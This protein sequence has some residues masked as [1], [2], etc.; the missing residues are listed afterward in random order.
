MLRVYGML[1]QC[2]CLGCEHSHT[3]SCWIEKNIVALL[4]HHFLKQCQVTFV[5]HIHQEL[6]VLVRH[7]CY[8]IAFM[9]GP[10][11]FVLSFLGVFLSFW[12]CFLSLWGVFPAMCIASLPCLVCYIINNGAGFTPGC[13]AEGGQTLPTLACLHLFLHCLP[14]Q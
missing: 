4:M 3:L 13:W 11:H 6:F 1:L 14:S 5:C 12:G 9:P 7:C 8:N 10:A 2:H